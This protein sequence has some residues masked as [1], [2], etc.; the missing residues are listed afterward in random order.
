MYRA[1]VK[2]AKMEQRDICKGDLWL[3]HERAAVG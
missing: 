3:A 2:E 1:R